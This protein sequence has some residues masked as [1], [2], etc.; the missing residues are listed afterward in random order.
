MSLKYL[1]VSKAR[2]LEAVQVG[3]V[4]RLAREFNVVALNKE[5]VVVLNQSPDQFGAHDLDIAKRKTCWS[6]SL[7][8]VRLFA[9]ADASIA[10]TRNLQLD[11]FD[12]KKRKEKEFYP[13]GSEKKFCAGLLQATLNIFPLQ[14]SSRRKIQG[15]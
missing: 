2:V 15:I 14:H 11:Y 3:Q 8:Y 13:V 4:A 9:D 7:P 12:V 5:G 6:L 10:D 1:V